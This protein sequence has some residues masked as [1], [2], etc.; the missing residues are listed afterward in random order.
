LIRRYVTALRVLLMAADAGL[1]IV[2]FAIVS[3]IRFGPDWDATWRSIGIE[4]PI[5]AAIYGCSWV[6]ILWATGMYRLRSRW[7]WRSEW[8]DLL[9]ATLLVAVVVFCALFAFKLPNV[10]RLF[11]LELF[12]LQAMTAIVSRAVL[13]LA[14]EM[15]RTRGYNARY[16]VVVGAGPE[17]IAF[18]S[19]IARHPEL[20]LKVIGFV[21]TTGGFGDPPT[22]R[23]TLAQESEPER[24][25]PAEEEA[26]PILGTIDRIE[27]IIH[28]TVVDEVAICLARDAWAFVEP[29]TSLCA[30]EGRIVRIPIDGGSPLAGGGRVEEFDGI[31]VLSLVRGPDRAVSLFIKRVLDIG[32]ATIALVALSPVFALI[33]ARIVV[34]DG[35]PVIF[36]QVRIGLHGRPFRV[37]KF[38]TMQPD[39]ESQLS[40]LLARNEIRG[41][42][43][44]LSDDPRLTRS[45]RFLRRSSLDELP[46][47]WNVL[48]GEM[49]LVGPRPPLPDEV[50]NYDLWHRRRLSMKPGI[51]GQWQVAARREAEFDRWVELDLDY[52]DRWSLWLDVKILLL[53]IP[54]VLNGAGR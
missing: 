11:L 5:L 9:R 21:A 22:R 12:G 4:A 42:A 54:A 10:S 27:A 44:K 17:A 26:W 34:L 30:E 33:A 24:A 23:S 53:T 46:Q 52:I 49:S 38:R 16:M 2:L 47:F 29:I 8:L 13:R 19:R 6:V 50:D 39:A 51:T 35:P 43:F 40:E 18:A 45:G 15:A 25:M 20:G 7:S 28:G 14:F 41:H 31:Q 37:V 1:A 32:G 48:M 3:A 36:R